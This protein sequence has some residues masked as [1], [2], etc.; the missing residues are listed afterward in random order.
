MSAGGPDDFGKARFASQ[1]RPSRVEIGRPRLP[2]KGWEQYDP[3]RKYL[4]KPQ[5][6]ARPRAADTKPVMEMIKEMLSE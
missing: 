3:V 1:E 6:A 4:G 5:S 2:L